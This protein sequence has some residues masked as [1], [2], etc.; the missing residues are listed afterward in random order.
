[1]SGTDIFFCPTPAH[2]AAGSPGELP[3]AYSSCFDVCMSG[4]DIWD[5]LTLCQWRLERDQARDQLQRLL[6]VDDGRDEFKVINRGLNGVINRGLNGAP[7][8]V[9]YHGERGNRLSMRLR[10]SMD[11]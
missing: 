6:R 7:Q 11:V 3:D 2:P 4:P 5:F 1:M 9:Q 8:E 10:D